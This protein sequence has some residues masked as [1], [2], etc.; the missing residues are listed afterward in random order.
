MPAYT[1]LEAPQVSE[2]SWMKR[3]N[4]ATMKLDH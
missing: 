2:Q 3:M 1:G 4:G